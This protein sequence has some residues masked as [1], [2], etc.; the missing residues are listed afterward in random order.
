MTEYPTRDPFWA[1]RYIRL[2]TKC[3]AVNEVGPYATLICMI[4]AHQE[5]AIRYVRPVTFSNGELQKLIGV[6]KWDT[7]NSA[8]SRASSKGWL[9]YESQGRKRPGVYWVTVPEIY[10]PLLSECGQIA[11]AALGLSPLNGYN[12]GYKDGYRDGYKD[13]YKDGY[14]SSSP[15][16]P[17]NP[18][19][20]SARAR[21]QKT[22]GSGSRYK[23]SE[24]LERHLLP[25][26]EKQLTEWANLVREI[27]VRDHRE[28]LVVLDHLIRYVRDKKSLAVK[29]ADDCLP[30]I[31][32]ARHQMEFWRRHP[33]QVPSDPLWSELAA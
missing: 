19:E 27:G 11:V 16:S 17:P 14:P 31:D 18:S 22:S 3:C 6:A 29:W 12:D 10:E 20:S 7:F 5:D 8:R 2:L 25:R 24:L 13:G 4:V 23:L 26:G 15:P 32:E 1:L 28:G 21:G 9:H 30:H 33:D